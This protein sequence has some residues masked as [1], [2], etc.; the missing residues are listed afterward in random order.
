[1]ALALRAVGMTA[2]I[3][4][5]A[6]V[7]ASVVVGGD[8]TDACVFAAFLNTG[9]TDITVALSSNSMATA[10]AAVLP[11]AGV[12]TGTIVLPHA[13]T[14]PV[15]FAIPG[16]PFKVTAIGSAAGPGNLFIT[17]CEV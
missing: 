14:A 4:V 10:T 13:M 15:A 11:T 9:A 3:A 7:S 8:V 6:T 17:P 5:T 16:C 12:P 2:V 1:M